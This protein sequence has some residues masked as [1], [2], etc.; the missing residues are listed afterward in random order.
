MQKA[1]G[2]MVHL[3]WAYGQGDGLVFVND[4]NQGQNPLFFGFGLDQSSARS[5]KLS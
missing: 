3:T 1:R 4:S 5:M 2:H